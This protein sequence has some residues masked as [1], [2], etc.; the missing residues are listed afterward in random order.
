MCAVLFADA[1]NF[2]RKHNLKSICIAVVL[3]FV[4]SEG[5]IHFNNFNNHGK[6][7]Y[8]NTSYFQPYYLS[9]EESTS[10]MTRK[11]NLSVGS[12]QLPLVQ[13]RKLPLSA[14]VPSALSQVPHERKSVHPI[15]MPASVFWLPC[16]HSV[17]HSALP[18]IL[19]KLV[20]RDSFSPS[21]C[22][23]DC[24][25]FCSNLFPCASDLTEWFSC[26]VSCM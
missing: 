20:S 16:P 23:I 14:S 15:P 4:F 9:T 3:V 1:I 8:S 21:Q 12:S 25:T 10:L 7:L 18:F 5:S 19:D 26:Q 22:M 13:T 2:S 17:R 24:I 11:Q 6:P